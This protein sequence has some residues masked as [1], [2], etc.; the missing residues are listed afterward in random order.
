LAMSTLQLRVGPRR[1]LKGR[2]CGGLD[3]TLV[4]AELG[5]GLRDETCVA[6]RGGSGE[7]RPRGPRRPLTF[8]HGAR[9]SPNSGTRSWVFHCHLGGMPRGSIGTDLMISDSLFQSRQDYLHRHVDSEPA[10]APSTFQLSILSANFGNLTR[11]GVTATLDGEGEMMPVRC[12]NTI[13][14]FLCSGYHVGLLQEAFVAKDHTW[15][16]FSGCLCLQK[17]LRPHC[18]PLN[19]DVSWWVGV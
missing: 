17:R 13:P 10:E 9:S 12:D 18:R 14:A 5:W 1:V 16:S 19:A 4:F 11:A 3:L 8:Q 15:F 7:A 2:Q 6:L